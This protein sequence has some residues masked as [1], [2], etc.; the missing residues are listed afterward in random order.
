MA[1]PDPTKLSAHE[2]ETRLIIFDNPQYDEHDPGWGHPESPARLPSIR[3]ALA[4]HHWPVRAGRPASFT[5]LSR[6][7]TEAYIDRIMAAS[8][9]TTRLDPDTGVSPGS[10]DAALLAAGSAVEAAEVTMAGRNG[11]VTCRP[12][13]H[14]ATPDRAMGF[15]LFNNAAIAAA[16]LAHLGYRVAVLDPDAH[17][18]NGTQDAFYERADVLYVSWHRAPF[19]PG[20]GEVEEIGAGA[21]AGFTLNIPLPLG[22]DDGLY[23]ASLQ[24]LA[25]PAV[26]RFAPDV[27]VFSAGF[28]QMEGDLLGGMDLS[29]EGLAVLY[30][31]FASR[32]PCMA[33]LEGGY[34]TH[35]LGGDVEVA[36]RAM[37]GDPAPDVV[38]R[39]RDDWR[40][41][42]GAWERLHPLLQ[43]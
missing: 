26:Q 27:V 22:A 1:H 12:P 36:A 32:W 38:V 35:R 9:Q 19:Y 24:R 33:V 42:F 6:V 30:H 43:G 4:P 5:E 18:G 2:R 17:H 16:H 8:G 37:A 10:V 40:E 11:F 21:G 25:L 31:A 7:H 20:T 29:R 14:H 3:R 39:I 23:L 41:I 34:N 13:G 15:C 28:D